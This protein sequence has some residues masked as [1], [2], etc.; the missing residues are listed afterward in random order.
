MSKEPSYWDRDWELRTPAMPDK[1][2]IWV[3]YLSLVA[4][5][6]IYVAWASAV[7]KV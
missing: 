3:L 1:W 5:L 7:G 6:I 2:Y 4:G